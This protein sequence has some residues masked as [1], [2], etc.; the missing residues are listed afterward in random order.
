[1]TFGIGAYRQGFD[2]LL[3]RVTIGIFLAVYNGSAILE[4]STVNTSRFVPRG[5]E[6]PRNVPIVHATD[7]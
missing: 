1:M 2:Q 7:G 6:L 4:P 5:I 3:D